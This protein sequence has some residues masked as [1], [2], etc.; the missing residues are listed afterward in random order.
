[1]VVYVGAIKPRQTKG[2]GKGEDGFLQ[3]LL[4]LILLIY[5]FLEYKLPKHRVL[6]GRNNQTVRKRNSDGDFARQSRIRF[7]PLRG[8]WAQCNVCG[9]RRDADA[10][11]DR[12]RT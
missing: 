8:Y 7:N 11:N 5:Y 4:E 1:L 6:R 9:R 3:Q 12:V 10:V 2:Y